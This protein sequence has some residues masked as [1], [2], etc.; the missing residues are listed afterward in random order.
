[1]ITKLSNK[2]VE[3]L[4]TYKDVDDGEMGKTGQKGQHAQHGLVIRNYI[5]SYQLS[6]TKCYAEDV[7]DR[8]NRETRSQ[9]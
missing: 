8:R 1:M 7:E 9:R 3:K 4:L 5:K 6:T 2:D